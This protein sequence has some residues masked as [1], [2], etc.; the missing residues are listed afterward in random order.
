MG[1]RSDYKKRDGIADWDM[2]KG[3]RHIV[4]QSTPSRRKLRDR[5]KHRA[6]AKMKI[7]NRFCTDWEEEK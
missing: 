3:C 7:R 5:L 2:N 6:R 1:R 4:D